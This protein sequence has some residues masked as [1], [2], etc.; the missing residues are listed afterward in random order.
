[1]PLRPTLRDIAIRAGFGKTTVSLALRNDPR[2]PE[3]TRKKVQQVADELGYRPDPVLSQIASHRWR[4][5]APKGSTLAFV[6]TN[7]P[8]LRRV[9]DGAAISGARAQAQ[10]MGY[11]LEHFRFEDYSDAAHLARVISNR[12]IRGVIVG[13]VMRE[14]LCRDFPWR[15]FAVIACNTGFHRPPV[16]LVMIDHA[17]AVVQAW[18][19]AE[20]RGYKRIGVALFDEG[21][22]IDEFDKTAAALYCQQP[23]ADSRRIPVLHFK[24]GDAEA[25]DTWVREHRPDVVLGFNESVYWTLK[26]RRYRVPTEIAFAALMVDPEDPES[27]VIAGMDYRPGVLGAAA[28]EHLDIALR[29]NR[30]GSPERLSVL[31]VESKWKEGDTLPAKVP[32]RPIK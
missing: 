25:V 7:H 1:M 5:V 30:V 13:Q 8:G 2:I 19:T 4:G 23:H 14:D 12:G 24:V 18:R 15:D 32:A 3:E 10:A 6:T 11:G 20:A 28:V 17:H 27:E 9:L 21:S 29:A 31:M 16:N 22:A 26:E